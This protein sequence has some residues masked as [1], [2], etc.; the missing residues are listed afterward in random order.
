MPE[1]KDQIDCSFKSNCIRFPDKNK[2]NNL[3]RYNKL[4][5]EEKAE[6]KKA[7]ISICGEIDKI[8]NQVHIKEY[9]EQGMK[10]IENLCKSNGDI[11]T[12]LKK[13]DEL[14]NNVCRATSSEWK[15]SFRKTSSGSWESVNIESPFFLEGAKKATV[16]TFFKDK[17]Y[18][19]HWNYT[20]ECS[21]L[22]LSEK[23]SDLKNWKDFYLWNNNIPENLPCDYIKFD[24]F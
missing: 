4:S 6:Q 9:E 10:I 19:H 20:F 18:P 2:T 8:N 5:E 11:V 21:Y 12:Y 3:D 22:G 7:V 1:D 24:I 17:K 14:Q 23:N 15:S 16:Q 13:M